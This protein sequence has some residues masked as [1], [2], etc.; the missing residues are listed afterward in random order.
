[1]MPDKIASYHFSPAVRADTDLDSYLRR[2]WGAGRAHL[3]GGDGDGD[4]ADGKP[5]TLARFRRW[6]TSRP[7]SWVPKNLLPNL[8][9]T[10]V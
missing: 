10:R 8:R 7:L 6:S 4:G 3:R 9:R 5:S 2:E 1:M